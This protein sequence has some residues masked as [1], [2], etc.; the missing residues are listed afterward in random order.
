MKFLEF[1]AMMC[2]DLYRIRIEKQNGKCDYQVLGAKMFLEL[3]C[4]WSYK[5]S[6]TLLENYG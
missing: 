6:G 2:L 5:V 4:I 1:G 3:C